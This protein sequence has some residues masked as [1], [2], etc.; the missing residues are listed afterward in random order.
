MT[1]RSRNTS[2]SLRCEL[3]EGRKLMAADLAVLEAV[4]FE[5][6]E[7]APQPGS[8]SSFENMAGWAGH[9]PGVAEVSHFDG[10][11]FDDIYN[12]IGPESAGHYSD[13]AAGVM[14]RQ[15]VEGTQ[16]GSEGFVAPVDGWPRP[17][18][19]HDQVD[20]VA[21]GTYDWETVYGF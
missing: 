6:A 12:V 16:V 4:E 21:A 9:Y 5:S 8:L 10:P 1:I 3:L 20:Q 19:I 2:R 15:L 18:L 11:Q 13:G 7:I 17:G 14:A